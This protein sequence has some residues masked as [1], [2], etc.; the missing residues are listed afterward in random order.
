MP[1]SSHHPTIFTHTGAPVP[2]NERLVANFW[3]LSCSCVTDSQ[4]MET[5]VAPADFIGLSEVG[6]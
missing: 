6:S 2:N 3:Y 1:G 4:F 5:Y